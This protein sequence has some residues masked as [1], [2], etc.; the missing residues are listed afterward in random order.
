MKPE[1]VLHSQEIMLKENK[2]LQEPRKKIA[3][4]SFCQLTTGDSTFLQ[5][6]WGGFPSPSSPL[7]KKILIALAVRED[8]VFLSYRTGRV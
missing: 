3:A 8:L 2:Q 6:R 5:G 1:I 7:A 4:P